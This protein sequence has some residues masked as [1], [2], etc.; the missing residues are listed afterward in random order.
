MKVSTKQQRIAELAKR[1]PEVSF[2]SLNHYLDLEWLEAAYRRLR[3]DSAPGHDAQTVQDYGEEL[4]ANLRS[5]L[6]RAKSGSYFAPP[7][8]RVYVPKGT[9]KELRPI[10]VPST[11]DK[12][13]Q[14][15]VAMLLEPIYEQDFLDC[16]YGFRPGRSAHDALD[17]LWRQSMEARVQWIL[18]VDISQFFDTLDHAQLRTLLHHRVRD[19]VIT[20]L[21]GKW[22][23]AGVLEQGAVHYPEQGTPQ[24]GSI[25]PLLS[26]VYLHYVLDLWFAAEVKPRMKGR[27]FMIRFADDGAPRRREG[28]LMN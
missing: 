8:R 25:S 26:N 24:G 3:K 20:R 28:V 17:A 23:N 18:D 14:R 2:T 9:G 10:G 11:E 5:L 6:G 15:A 7:V 27:A 16:S 12:L 19:G 13:L 1:S 21:V 4:E 22:L